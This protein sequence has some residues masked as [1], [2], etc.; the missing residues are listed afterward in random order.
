MKPY[1]LFFLALNANAGPDTF[2]TCDTHYDQ[3]TQHLEIRQTH[4]GYEFE[5]SFQNG[6]LKLTKQEPIARVVDE[7][8]IGHDGVMRV[9]H[10]PTA[11]FGHLFGEYD[12]NSGDIHLS[13]PDDACIFSPPAHR[14]V[15]A[16]GMVGLGPCRTD[17]P[18]A[19][20]A[21]AKEFA[22]SSAGG[23]CAPLTAR[24]LS[25][26]DLFS[27]CVEGEQNTVARALFRCE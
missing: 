8:T 17:T 2:V 18:V 5:A 9:F 27:E 23:L 25:D 22:A 6:A 20:P 16:R 13:F 26:F 1:Y 14:D 7:V 10:S 15:A 19:Y 24:R 11:G 4:E 3:V 21:L 12:F